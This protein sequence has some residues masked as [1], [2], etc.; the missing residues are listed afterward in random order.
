MEQSVEPQTHGEHR[1]TKRFISLLLIVLLA[2]A[3]RLALWAQPLHEPAN[4]ETEYIAVAYDLLEGRGWQFYTHYHWLR[5]PLYP[6]FLAGSLWLS[7]GNLHLAALPNIALS[8]ATV[9]LV[10]LLTEAL[11]GSRAGSCSGSRESAAPAL[12]ALLAALLF[13]LNTFASLYMSETLFTFLFTAALLLLVRWKQAAQWGSGSEG[14]QGTQRKQR[15]IALLA[16]AGLLYG[17]ATLTRSVTV[18]FLPVVVLWIVA[19]RRWL[20]LLPPLAGKPWPPGVSLSLPWRAVGSGLLFVICVLLPIAPWT[21]RNCQAYEQCILVETGF[22]YNLWAFS[23][24][25]EDMSEIFRVL[26]NI[27]DPA[28]RAAEASRRGLARLRED[29]AIVLRK[30]WPDWGS[31]W[32]IKPIQDRFLVPEYYSDPPPLVFL[33]ALLLDDALYV[34]ILVAGAVGFYGA[35]ARRE[36]RLPSLLVLLWIASIATTTMLTHGEGRYRHFF[37]SVLIPYAALGMLTIQ[38]H[39]IAMLSRNDKKNAK[40]TESLKPTMLRAGLVRLL[41]VALLVLILYPLLV[42]YPWE[43]A[44][45]GAVRSFYR[46]VG[47]TAV[48][49]D[50]LEVAKQAYRRAYEAQKTAEGR[51]LLGD[52]FRCEG[53]LVQA[54]AHYRAGWHR[55][56]LYVGGNARLGDVLR[57]Q[58]RNDEAIEAFAGYFVDEQAVVSWSWEH[59]PVAP[60][61]FLD[62]GNGLDFGYVSGV[63]NAEQQQGATARWSNGRGQFRL[64]VS[65]PGSPTASGSLL[66][67]RLAAP[68][69]GPGPVPAEV[70]GGGM[71]QPVE[72]AQTWQRISLLLPPPQEKGDG[73]NVYLVQLRSPVFYPP[74]GRELGILVDWLRVVPHVRPE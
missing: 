71:C 74:D 68:H 12:A 11:T 62:V 35:V 38:A 13:T 47:D 28:A 27:P 57:A 4:D 18:A 37:F 52:V 48:A 22:S 42:F 58:G 59:L 66:T 40:A 14:F 45:G 24:P 10:F 17:L 67:M 9:A 26:E 56:K 6:L 25:R 8:V 31:L 70:C 43:W 54:E 55:Q 39:A 61:R 41:T 1:E 72:V 23:E 15:G 32:R 46:L 3:L 20:S 64:A 21:I 50:R 29:P 53:N 73:R 51:L 69:P 49:L 7:G 5:A 2:L 60:R 19:D 63:H 16:L 30:L 34:V 44:A 65:S 36:S 33:A